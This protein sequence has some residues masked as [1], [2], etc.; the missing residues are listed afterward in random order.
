M[1]LI[2][3]RA[4]VAQRMLAHFQELTFGARVPSDSALAQRFGLGRGA[5]RG[6][7]DDFCRR[8][9]VRRERGAGTHWLGL[10]R[11]FA[12]QEVPS[13]NLHYRA[14]GRNPGF[15][16][17]DCRIRRAVRLERD[18]L[19]LPANSN[20]WKIQRLF[21]L[22]GEKISVGTSVLPSRALPEMLAEFDMYGSIY[23]TLERR[24]GITVTRAWQRLQRVEVPEFVRSA[25]Q[26]DDRTPVHLVESLN[27][28]SDGASIE[29][30]RSYVRADE[31]GDGVLAG[32]GAA[33]RETVWTG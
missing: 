21:T 4:D 14:I 18:Y 32:T 8:G 25:L 9:L 20:V 22:E 19:G 6:I 28:R 23:R 15:S 7:M 33:N 5:V 11:P 31:I 1:T 24:Y 12:S 16:L 30:A 10:P 3:D 26:L 27:R 2:K 13:Y 29:Y 17:I